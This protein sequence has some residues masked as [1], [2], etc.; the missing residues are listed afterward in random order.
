MK[1]MMAH[2]FLPLSFRLLLRAAAGLGTLLLA[3][4]VAAQS[5]EITAIPD[6][7]SAGML[8]GVVSGVNPATHKVAAYL[9]V[10]GGGWWNKSTGATI[11]P[12]G[13]F[14]VNIGTAGLDEY[15]ST[16]SVAVVPNSTSVPDGS[17]DT[18]ILPGSTVASD[19]V[20]RYGRNLQFGGRNW[21]VKE[22]P[23][24]VGPGGNR[25]SA[26]ED[27]VWVDEDG[28]HL[29]IHHHGGQ[30]RSTEVVLTENLGYGTYYF[31]TSSEV[32]DLNVNA[33]FGAFTW[34]SFGDDPRITDWPW[35]EIDFEDSRW[36]N[37]ADPTTSQTVIQPYYVTG[38]LDRYTIPDLSANPELT[39]AF[40]WAPGQIDWITALGNHS[41]QVVLAG[42]VPAGDVIDQRTY[43]DN[44]GNHLVPDASRENFRFNLWLNQDAPDGNQP[45]EVIISDFVFIPFL[46]G[47]YDGSGTVGAA[48]FEMWKSTFGQV[49]APY[50]GADGNGNGVIDAADYSV[51]RDNVGMTIGS[52]AG[53]ATIVPEPS[54]MCLTVTVMTFV[55]MYRAAL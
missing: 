10:E 47:D 46:S 18:H 7:E 42:D 5:V 4:V 29:T 37:A 32:E 9:L 2:A 55:A 40:T 35:R 49:V 23:S 28:M 17:S 41:P 8:S 52:G 48:D 14:S 24:P 45:V 13:T 22:A 11:N 20:Q 21:G 43:L 50:G 6:Y 15:A 54:T 12:D 26:D 16:Y 19:W 30:W 25:F 53:S 31:R 33:T 34:D 39:R 38:N 27:D 44:N 51:W 3:A 36:G 1:I